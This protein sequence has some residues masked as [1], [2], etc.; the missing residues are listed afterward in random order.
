MTLSTCPRFSDGFADADGTPV[1]VSRSVLVIFKSRG[2][3]CVIV[4]EGENTLSYINEHE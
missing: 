4:E 2:T 3:V 1:T